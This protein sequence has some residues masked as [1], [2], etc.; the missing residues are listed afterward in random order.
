MDQNTKEDL[1]LKFTKGNFDGSIVNKNSRSINFFLGKGVSYKLEGEADIFTVLKL[2]KS[3]NPKA[4]IFLIIMIFS[5]FLIFCISAILFTIF[6]RTQNQLG[7]VIILFIS[8]GALFTILGA[9]YTSYKR[10]SKT[11]SQG[12]K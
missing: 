4:I 5:F 12:I 3:G 9:F 6:L 7:L 8:F 10:Y 11:K 1:D 2:L